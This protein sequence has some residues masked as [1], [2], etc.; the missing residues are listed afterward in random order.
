MLFSGRV[1]EKKG[2]M[3]GCKSGIRQQV[4]EIFLSILGLQECDTKPNGFFCLLLCLIFFFYC[5][6]ISYT[7]DVGYFLH[8]SEIII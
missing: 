6:N 4:P 5:L 7:C 8:I 2:R 1:N 3:K